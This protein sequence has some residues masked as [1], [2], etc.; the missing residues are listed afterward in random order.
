MNENEP[1]C[2]VRILRRW[3]DVS[4]I[5]SGH[6]FRPVNRWNRI[7]VYGDRIGL[8]PQ[9]IDKVVKKLMR[10]AGLDPKGYGAHSLRAGFVT[11]AALMGK[12]ESEIMRHT[13]HGS[14]TM[15]RRYIRVAELH[16]FNAT[17]GIGL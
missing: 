4:G 7:V 17:K 10:R 2:P 8:W 14:F 3:L 6:V 15:V 12:T 13:G 16:K 11:Q 1:Y 5:T 9:Y